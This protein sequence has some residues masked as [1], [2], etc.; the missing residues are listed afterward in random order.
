MKKT[1]AILIVV[2]VMMMA[3][4]ATTVNDGIYST[5]GESSQEKV[6]KNAGNTRWAEYIEARELPKI[7]WVKKL[8]Q[9]IYFD[10]EEEVMIVVIGV[11]NKYTF[12]SGVAQKVLDS[13][14]ASDIIPIS[15][16]NKEKAAEF[17][18]FFGEGLIIR[19]NHLYTIM[20]QVSIDDVET[21]LQS[22]L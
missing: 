6:V 10:L 2:S 18:L 21:F 16:I 20:T 3:A 15:R 11:R 9:G 19:E 8:K 13:F 12:Q 7:F 14:I 22:I 1:F 4:C 17:C 5:V